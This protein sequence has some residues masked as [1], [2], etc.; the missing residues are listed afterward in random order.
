MKKLSIVNVYPDVLFN[1]SANVINLTVTPKQNLIN[2]QIKLQIVNSFSGLIFNSVGVLQQNYEGNL[3]TSCDFV[4]SLFDFGE[5]KIKLTLG[6]NAVVSSSY[7]LIRIL[8]KP[9]I[10]YYDPL[11]MSQSDFTY[12]MIKFADE[13]LSRGIISDVK[14]RFNY[15]VK[16]KVSRI[17]SGLFYNRT[18]LLCKVG[19]SVIEWESFCFDISFNDFYDF[20]TTCDNGLSMSFF[21]E[22]SKVLP[23]CINLNNFR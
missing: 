21:F 3:Y 4:P 23:K 6:G 18:T 7:K 12:F 8:K 14:C 15:Q 9:G 13:F 2:Y 5:Y 19:E 22:I 20:I 11:F 17:T 1:D 10:V 16:N